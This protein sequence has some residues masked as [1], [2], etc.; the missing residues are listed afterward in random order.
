MGAAVNLGGAE[1]HEMDEFL[2]KVRVLRDV[3]VEAAYGLCALRGDLIP[4]QT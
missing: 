2:G 1:K 4:S 3:V